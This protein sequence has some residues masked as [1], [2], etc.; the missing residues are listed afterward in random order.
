M[1]ASKGRREPPSA[2]SNQLV[3]G[4]LDKDMGSFVLDKDMGSFLDVPA[5]GSN[6]SLFQPCSENKRLTL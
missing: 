4:V 5:S 6:P 2:P 3:T 1:V